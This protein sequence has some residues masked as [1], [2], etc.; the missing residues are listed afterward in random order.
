M[1]IK[2]KSKVNSA[3]ILFLDNLLARFL[4]CRGKKKIKTKTSSEITP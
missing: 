2:N 1:Y 4:D 3:R